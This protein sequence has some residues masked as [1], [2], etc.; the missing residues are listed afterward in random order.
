MKILFQMKTLYLIKIIHQI[1]LF[2]ITEISFI[3]L[4][5]NIDLNHTELIQN[6]ILI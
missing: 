3:P 2:E 4:S 1:F 5:R 6:N